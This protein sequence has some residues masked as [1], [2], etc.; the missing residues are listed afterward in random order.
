ESME[1]IISLCT[2]PVSKTIWQMAKDIWPTK[3]GPWPT[4]HIGLILG[5]GTIPLPHTP[6]AGSQNNTNNSQMKKG[7]SQLLR[8]LISKSAY[9]IWIICCERVIRESTHTEDSVK[10][11]WV[12]TID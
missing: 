8:I 2:N 3:H 10:R 7:A 4:P 11:Q 1:H 9:L 12:N 5:C 6:Q